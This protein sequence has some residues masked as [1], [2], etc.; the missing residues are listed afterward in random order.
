[1][2]RAEPIFTELRKSAQLSVSGAAEFLRVPIK[3]IEAFENG[4]KRPAISTIKALE[5]LA[6]VSN[7]DDPKSY[8]NKADQIQV[9]K[10]LKFIDLF[11]GIGGFHLA[12]HSLDAECVFASEINIHARKTYEH[13]HRK[14][15]S[16]LFMNKKFAGDIKEVA[17]A[18]IPDFDIL[19]GGFP[20]QPFSQAG[21][22]R[23][24]HEAKENRGNLFFD[25][26]NIIEAKQPSAFFL[27][28]VRHIKNHDE[29]KTFAVIQKTLED[30]GYS[31][32]H[33]M[34][35]ASDHG[36]PQHRP[37]IF[38]VGFRGEKSEESTFK[39]PDAEP[40][41]MTMSDIFGKP[42]NK[43]VGYTLRVG[44]RGSGL[45][46]RR[47]W[48]TYSVA[49]NVIRLNSFYGRKM[50]GFPDNFEFPVSETQAMKQLGNSV[51]VP[52]IRAT[53][54]SLIEYLGQPHF[55]GSETL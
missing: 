24:F 7:I 14:I 32:H 45:M 46:D 49:G 38:M 11:A 52:A 5:G 37:R 27:E 25:I 50:M 47:N 44:G 21:Y 31:F 6:L 55:A 54:K 53:A 23:G 10:P 34:V 13:N 33:K 39:F 42:C 15:S 1:M 51:A 8:R 19:C 43:A 35:K 26:I 48:D 16:A 3:E 2:G 36:L 40:L 41:N 9:S 30:L 29:G 28:N 20:C 22:K 18:D 17:P 12:L 4:A